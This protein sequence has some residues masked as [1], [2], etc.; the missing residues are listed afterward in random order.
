MAAAASANAQA[1]LADDANRMKAR[2]EEEAAAFTK[3]A[4]LTE[5]E[6]KVRGV[7]EAVLL[8]SSS[9]AS[10]TGFPCPLACT[11]SSS[12]SSLLFS[13]PPS[14]SLSWLQEQLAKELE[15]SKKAD[16]QISDTWRRI[17]RL[18]K[19]RGCALPAAACVGVA[20]C[21]APPAP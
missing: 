18:A 10:S 13:A 16:L 3:A 14:L 19:V 1:A 2:T 9:F 4:R 6:L 15:T 7:G 17:L 20:A 8:C 21:G 11:P 12:S 5:H